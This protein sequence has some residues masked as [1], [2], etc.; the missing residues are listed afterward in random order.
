[1][2]GSVEVAE[3]GSA[4]GVAKSEGSSEGSRRG[5]G[6][7]GGCSQCMGLGLGEPL[8]VP[9]SEF[10]APAME[11]P[12]MARGGFRFLWWYLWWGVRGVD[13]AEKP[14]PSLDRPVVGVEAV[15]GGLEFDMPAQRLVIILSWLSV[16]EG[17][18]EVGT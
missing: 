13:G 18:S 15:V 7:G 5:S 1:M 2:A 8:F 12:R 10:M 4:G 6:D 14:A 17:A 16:D 9:K 3:A 11:E